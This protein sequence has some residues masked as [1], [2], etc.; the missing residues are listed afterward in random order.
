MKTL[1]ALSIF[2]LVSCA[3]NPRP[4]QIPDTLQEA[5]DS[6]FRSPENRRRDQYRHPIETLTFFGLKPDMTVIEVTPGKGWYMEILAPYLSQKGQYI[7]AIPVPE[8]PY[9]KENEAAISAWKQKYF[10]V[11]GKMKYVLF[12]EK[13]IKLPEDGSIDMILTF[14]NVH[15]WMKEKFA[16]DAFDAFFKALRPGGILGVVDHRAN[17]DE[18]DDPFAKDGYVK[19]QDVIEMAVTA[20]FRLAGSSE[21]N[22]NPQDTKDYPGGV[23]TLPPTLK[24][25]D[26]DRDKYLAIGESDR[27]TLKFI[28]PKR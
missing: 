19:E 26:K 7:M 3:S 23:W 4:L 10:Q 11:G 27:M 25:G 28:K 9:E 15:N 13:D 21:I 2:L 18:K 6:G 1:L 8:R 20:G 16:R 12:S 24:L 14:R 22:A 5:V 17:P